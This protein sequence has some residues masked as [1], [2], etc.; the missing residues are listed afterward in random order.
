MAPQL[1]DFD[2]GRLVGMLEVGASVSDVA[3][4][5][6]IHRK[7]VLRWWNRFH[8]TGEVKRRSGSGRPRITSPLQDRKLCLMV[9][10]NRFTPVSHLHPGWAA[11]CGI[12]CSSRTARRIVLTAGLRSCRPLA[13]IPLS[14]SHRR[15]R[16]QWAKEHL[17]W[18]ENQWENVLWTD[19]SR[20]TLDF[21]DGR[22][23]VRR[24]PGERFCD[25]AVAQHDRYGGGSVMIWAGI[26]GAGRTAVVRINGTLT[27]N[28]YL[29]EVMLPIIVPTVQ[30]HGLLL[31]QDNA[32]PHVARVIMDALRESD[33]PFLK[34]PSRSPDLSPIEHLWDELG[35]RVYQSQTRPVPTS[36]D[37]LTERLVEEFRAIPQETILQLIRSLPNRLKECIRH[38]GGH[39]RY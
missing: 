12:N 35:R 17:E 18:T 25:C 34:W 21:C 20:F 7:T 5:L 8:T 4:R 9:K 6:N 15:S 22:V 31:Q 16:M 11:A 28:R 36:L 14:P 38:S 19:E 29:D 27:A 13:R 24:L 33:I 39:T 1:T 2:K 26:W 10:R 23:R 37:S 3:R 32:R 30:E